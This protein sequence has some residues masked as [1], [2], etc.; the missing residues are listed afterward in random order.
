MKLVKIIPRLFVFVF[1]FCFLI[2]CISD[3]Y[4]NVPPLDREPVIEPDYSG[5]TIPTNIAPMNFNI[6][7][8]GELFIIRATSSNGSGLQLKSSDGRV[9]FPMR[10]WK[11]LLAVS[12]KG[13]IEIEILSEDNEGNIIKYEPFNMNVVSEPVDPYLWYRLLYPG[14]ESWLDLK[15]VQRSTE[16]F[17]EASIF[18]NQLLENNC[19]N[20]HSSQQNNPEKFLLHVRGSMGGTYFVDGKEVTRRALQTEQMPASAVYPAWHPSGKYVAFSSNKTVQG[21][22]MRP[23]K[24]IEVYDLFSSMVIYDTGKNE[25]AAIEESDTVKYMETFPSWSPGGDFL[26]YCRAIQVEEGFDYRDVKYNLIRKS[27]DQNSGVFG[28]AELV[29]NAQEINKS[30]SFPVISPDGQYLVLTL[31][32][33]GT[34]SIWHKEADL[35]LLNLKSGKVDRMDLVNSDE[36]E[37]YHSWS[38]NGKWLVFSSK[39]GNGLAA[40][41][42]FAYF[43]SPENIGKPFVLPQKDPTLYERLEKTFN[44]PEFLTGKIRTGPRDFAR[45]SKKEAVN[46]SWAG[47]K[48]II[49]P[50]ELKKQTSAEN[51]EKEI[52]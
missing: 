49:V 26:Y 40:R 43:G 46:A 10:A 51:E 29:F 9:R 1:T 17:K 8:D 42:Y 6:V 3:N 30:V 2:G 50:N 11:K 48:T 27:F 47:E 41:P 38:S 13:K 21:F 35:Y 18:E 32:D 16:N 52:Y 34:F 24:N 4:N 15:I 19:V 44:R 37:S 7:E 5:V 36:T 33:Y 31:H 12:Q 23:E 20:C 14:Y 22:H 28:N 25:I 45:T 39:R